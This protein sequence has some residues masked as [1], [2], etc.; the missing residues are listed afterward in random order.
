MPFFCVQMFDFCVSCLTVVG[1]FSYAPDMKLW[2][3]QEGLVSRQWPI[4][5][6]LQFQGYLQIS[7][8]LEHKYFFIPE[9]IYSEAVCQQYFSQV[10]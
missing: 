4:Y 10:L 7:N 3:C 6:Y 5:V 2:L 8:L 9:Q 1:Y